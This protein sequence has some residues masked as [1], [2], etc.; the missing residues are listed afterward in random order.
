[1]YLHIM[2]TYIY[3]YIYVKFNSLSVF[4]LFPDVISFMKLK[5]VDPPAYLY[6]DLKVSLK[7]M[8]YGLLCRIIKLTVLG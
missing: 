6:S 4:R 3:I 8:V 2:Y 7:F 1:M 5:G